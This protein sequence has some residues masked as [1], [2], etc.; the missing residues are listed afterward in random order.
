MRGISLRP[1]SEPDSRG[2]V[3]T[4]VKATAGKNPP[5]INQISDAGALFKPEPQS[6]R[7]VPALHQIPEPG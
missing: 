1:E 5:P 6:R 2:A 3:S 4:P 7:Q